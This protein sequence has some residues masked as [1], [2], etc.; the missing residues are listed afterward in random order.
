[1]DDTNRNQTAR[2]RRRH[3][4]LLGPLALALGLALV[5]AA[6]GG[7]DDSA[8]GSSTARSVTIVD[9][10]SGGQ[11]GSSFAVTL[12]PS[13]PIGEPDTGR[14][15]VHLHFDGSPDYEIVYETTHMVSGLTPGMHRVQAVLAN[16]DH[17]ETDVRSPEVT[18]EVTGPGSS[19]QPATTAVPSGGGGGGNGG[20]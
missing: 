1:M 3:L 15:H 14:M 7:D 4:R 2:R 18:F 20:Y 17:S 10:A 12:Q 11:V 19:G 16:P 6:C 8:S 9:P 13:V 5:A